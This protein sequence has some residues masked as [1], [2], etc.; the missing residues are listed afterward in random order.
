MESIKFQEE[1]GNFPGQFIN[2][3]TCFWTQALFFS[4]RTGQSEIC[5][6]K[7]GI[8]QTMAI[9]FLQE[10]RYDILRTIKER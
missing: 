6:E 4:G 8:S 9:D 7:S 10:I 1:K 3:D 5:T 2:Y